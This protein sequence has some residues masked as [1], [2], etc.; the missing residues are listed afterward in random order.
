MVEYINHFR[1]SKAKD[2]LSSSDLTITEI[3]SQTG[4]YNNGTFIRNLTRCYSCESSYMA[5]CWD[6][7]EQ[8]LLN[9]IQRMVNANAA[10]LNF[11]A[12]HKQFMDAL[13]EFADA[14]LER[15]KPFSARELQDIFTSAGFNEL[16]FTAD[17]FMQV[18]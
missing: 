14:K 5:M 15:N 2:L 17:E 6:A 16:P 12:N 4:Y 13:D 9:D 7:E 8:N 3:A 1:I 18:W 11:M 10:I